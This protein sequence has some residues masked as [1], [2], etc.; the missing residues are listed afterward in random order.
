MST[1]SN[2]NSYKRCVSLLRW[3]CKKESSN[4]SFSKTSLTHSLNRRTKRTRDF[5]NNWRRCNLG[6][7]QHRKHRR[8]LKLYIPNS[9]SIWNRQCDLAIRVLKMQWGRTVI[10]WI[11]NRLIM[12]C[13]ERKWWAWGRRIISSKATVRCSGSSWSWKMRRWLILRPS[14]GHNRPKCNKQSTSRLLRRAWRASKTSW[15]E[16]EAPAKEQV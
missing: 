2:L 13:S 10:R 1:S 6:M 7:S 16:V 9:K 15:K 14:M 8:I 3:K 12:K 11:N 5:N 4:N